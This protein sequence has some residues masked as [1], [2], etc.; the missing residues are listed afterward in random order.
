[1]CSALETSAEISDNIPKLS[2]V[3]A[4]HAYFELYSSDSVRVTTA[5]KLCAHASQEDAEKLLQ[6]CKRYDLLNEFYQSHGDW[7][8]VCLSVSYVG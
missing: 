1:V 7:E 5:D 4:S 3:A 8:K 6:G 2:I